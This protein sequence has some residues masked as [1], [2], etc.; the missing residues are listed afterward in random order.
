MGEK[1]VT[2][3]FKVPAGAGGTRLDRH[4]ASFLKRFSRSALQRMIE[5]GRVLLNG[6]PPKAHTRLKGGETLE[7]LIPSRPP[8][9]PEPQPLPLRVLHE[10]EDVLVVDKEAGMVVHPVGA[11]CR[12]TLVNALL[13]HCDRL[14]KGGEGPRPGIVHRL[15][16]DTS[17]VMV[18]AKSD[19]ALKS[20]ASQFKNRKVKKE[21]LALVHGEPEREEGAITGAISR[22]LRDRKKMA[23][24]PLDGRSAET[25][26]YV[27]DRLR[28]YA[29]L[30][31]MPRTGRTHQI[32]VHLSAS[33]HPVLGDRMYGTARQWRQL[34]VEVARQM[35]HAKRLGFFH[36][37]TNVYRVFTAP[38]P[39]DMGRVLRVLRRRAREVF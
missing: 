14:P 34:D 19:R 9:K 1:A 37:A 28:G 29:F 31:L 18:V 5:E 16:K 2:R 10:D 12:D 17:G 27:L 30:L 36:P 4:L 23:V 11:R 22:H 35:L 21:Y 24:R 8:P 26:Y 6:S 39:Q 15:D 7:V 33:G 32:R 20:L 25:L 3:R 38:M 13:H